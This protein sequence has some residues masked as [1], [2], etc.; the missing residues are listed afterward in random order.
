MKILVITM[1]ILMYV[2]MIF[3]Q[4]AERLKLHRSPLRKAQPER[5]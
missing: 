2:V 4:N 3:F 5:A 1:F